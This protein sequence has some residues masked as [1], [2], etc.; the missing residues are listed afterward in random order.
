MRVQDRQ[1]LPQNAK[2]GNRSRLP[3]LMI[4][5]LVASVSPHPHSGCRLTPVPDYV[6]FE[7]AWYDRAA[8]ISHYSYLVSESAAV[9][10][11]GSVPVVASIG[12][13]SWVGALLGALA[14]MASGAM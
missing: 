14:A 11:A 10:F 9:V 6:Q 13:P 2:E 4:S 5:L 3:S 7:Q 8:T 12:C 1:R